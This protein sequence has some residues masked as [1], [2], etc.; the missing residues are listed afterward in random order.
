MLG[1]K[2][3]NR[4]KA[5]LGS[6]GIVILLLGSAPLAGM[7]FGEMKGKSMGAKQTPESMTY[8]MTFSAPEV[9][10]GEK[11]SYVAVE[12]ADYHTIG[13]GA[14][15]MPVAVRTFTFPFN[16]K[17]LKVDCEISD[18]HT[19]SIDK[20]IAP[21][22]G[23]VRMDT[24]AVSVKENKKIYSSSE[25]YPEKWFDYRIGVGMQ[26]GKHVVF[27]TVE[28]HPARYFPASGAVEYTDKID[29]KIEFKKQQSSFPDTY[30]LLIIT[31]EKFA[32]ALQPLVE[33]K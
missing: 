16:T 27:L 8:S 29:I 28:A 32:D 20:K 4:T 26:N 9:L 21:S 14:P 11:Y 30:D 22:V 6:I 23:A 19:R 15:A 31:P 2:N 18:I 25:P 33:H 3:M 24:H 1:G 10:Y 7:Q 17:I 13:K 12:G 5:I